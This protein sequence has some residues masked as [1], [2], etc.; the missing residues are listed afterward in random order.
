MNVNK[1]YDEN[2]DKMQELK[3]TEQVCVFIVA[4]PDNRP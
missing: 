3:E 4:D 1:Y 2:S